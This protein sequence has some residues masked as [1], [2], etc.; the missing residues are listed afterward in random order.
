[1]NFIFI[2]FYCQFEKWSYEGSNFNWLNL[3]DYVMSWVNWLFNMTVMGCLIYCLGTTY[4]D[5]ILH[6]KLWNFFQFSI[7]L[8]RIWEWFVKIH[9][10]PSG[11]RAVSLFP[12]TIC[13]KSKEME[14]YNFDIN[15]NKFSFHSIYSRRQ[16][17]QSRRPLSAFSQWIFHFDSFEEKAK[18]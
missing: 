15:H 5:W 10:Q 18:M 3:T 4:C 13:L 2:L 14:N 11:H 16:P 9:V 17:E 7:K 12:S 8:K 1:M 6:I